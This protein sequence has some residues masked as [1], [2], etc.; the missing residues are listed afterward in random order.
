[1]TTTHATRAEALDDT[2][3]PLSL[4]RVGIDTYRE[5]VAYLHRD[6]DLY[7]AEGF[8]ALSKV[9]IR[10]NGQ[11]ILASL[12]V[13]DDAAIVDCQQ[14][15][16]SED[17]FEALGVEEGHPVSVSQ[18]EP[19][20]SV[21]ALHRK[22]AGLGI[23]RDIL[24][25]GRAAEKMQAII[26]AQGSRPFDPDDPPLAP[27]RF[28]VLAAADGVVT[29]IDHFKLARIARLAGAPKAAGAGVDLLV[30]I[31]DPVATGQPLYRVHAAYCNELAFAHQSTERESGIAI[32][33]AEE[34]TRLNV[35]F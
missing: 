23:A 1:M 4:K 30:R 32:G 10:A 33:R 6:C 24:D 34:I 28:E 7:R 35:E 14:L 17:A 15:G 16:L 29:G 26:A 22:L 13:V 3:S 8:Q 21:P 31:G 18:A 20:A 5:N 11:R 19:P 27:R 2:L 9:E 25:D 12:N